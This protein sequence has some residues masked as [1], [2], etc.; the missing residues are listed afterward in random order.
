VEQLR[1][2]LLDNMGLYAAIRWQFG[3]TCGR[4]GL[5]C[6]ESL[7]PN[8]LPIS[9]E[10]AIAIFRMVQESLTNILKHARATAAHL[11]VKTVE[12]DMVIIIRDNGT[13]FA[14]ERL[15]ATG[16]SGWANMRQ[17]A[18]SL[19]GSWRAGPG[20]DGRGTEIEVRLPLQRIQ[21]A[22]A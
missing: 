9:Q 7:P 3:E 15:A 14:P 12:D 22:P 20:P 17:R 6:T 5:A 16:G 19:G 21:I 13:G 11:E 18:G 8:E 4:A 1:P 2:T 10:A